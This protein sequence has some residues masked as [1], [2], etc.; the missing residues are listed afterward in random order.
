MAYK[1]PEYSK[2]YYQKNKKRIKKYQKEYREKYGKNNLYGNRFI[3]KPHVQKKIQEAMKEQF[4]DEYYKRQK[5]DTKIRQ[6][7][8]RLEQVVELN[9]QG[10]FN[11]DI[12]NRL[13]IHQ[14]I[15]SYNLMRV[16]LKRNRTYRGFES[17]LDYF[18]QSFKGKKLTR[19]QLQKEDNSLYQS[20]IRHGQL[21][22]AGLQMKRRQFNGDPLTFFN[23]HYKSKR[24]TR[25]QLQKEDISLY[26]TLRR[27]GQLEEAIP[28][29]YRGCKSPLTYFNKYI[30]RQKLTRGQ[31]SKA[32]NSLYQTLVRHGQLD[33]AIPATTLFKK[34]KFTSKKI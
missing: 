18:N 33:K 3:D 10:L 1:N 20:L 30:K 17:P 8:N 23:E 6:E 28:K 22:K 24:L 2:K 15:V 32:D 14:S 29:K 4:P 31:L 12:A 19:G 16:G 11:K 34:F 13:G 27:Y 5:L 26:Q 7:P 9:Q 21:D 25:G